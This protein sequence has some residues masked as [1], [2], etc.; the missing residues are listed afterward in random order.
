[1]LS[2]EMKEIIL[3]ILNQTPRDENYNAGFKKKKKWM[4]LMAGL[5]LQ[6][7]KLSELQDIALETLQ[8]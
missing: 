5:T 7:E 8:N 2:R 3:K 4:W 1:M 6:E